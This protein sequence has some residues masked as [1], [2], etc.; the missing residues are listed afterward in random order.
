[1]ISDSSLEELPESLCEI[2]GLQEGDDQEAELD[3]IQDVVEQTIKKLKGN[4]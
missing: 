4:H 1:M 3:V 2:L